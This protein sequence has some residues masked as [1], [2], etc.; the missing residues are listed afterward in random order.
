[1]HIIIALLVRAGKVEDSPFN[2]QITE[3]ISYID[4]NISNVTVSSLAE[5]FGYSANYFTKIFKKNIGVAPIEYVNRRK[6][7][8]AIKKLL[9]TKDS[10]ESIMYDLSFYNKTH[11]YSLFKRYTG[12]LPKE[13]RDSNVQKIMKDLENFKV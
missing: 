12:H 10:I 11:F 4:E 6:I 2:N 13:I 1:M 9:Q 7:I 8:T 3:I 5:H